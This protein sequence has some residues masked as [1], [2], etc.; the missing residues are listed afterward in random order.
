M[1]F[2]NMTIKEIDNYLKTLSI[3]KLEKEVNNLKD[4][5]RISAKKLFAKYNNKIQNY[6]QE[7][8]RLKTLAKFEQALYT[9]GL[10]YIVGIDEAGRGP[11]AGPVYAA[12]VI[13]K[14]NTMIIGIND[15]KKLTESKREK[16]YDIIIKEAIDYSIVSVS[17]KEIDEINILQA[18]K[19]A[20][21]RTL[22]NLKVNPQHILI[23]GNESYDL[24][25][26]YTSII[27]GDSLS[28]SIAAASILAKVS[29][30]NYMKDMDKVYPEY[31]FSKHKG[32]GS[33]EH[34]EAI[35]Y[36]GLCPIHRRSFT[37]KIIKQTML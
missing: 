13:L 30:D 20:M 2:T 25:L 1:N 15:S 7:M 17:E 32:Y 29:R 35:R 36:Y 26:P 22:A 33:K 3:Y 34:I 11:L 4:L 31:N 27:K 23:D 37:K 6:Y 12:A 28:I 5:S 18:S 21:I 10:K 24:S 19:K 16:L 14:P 8:E 9:S